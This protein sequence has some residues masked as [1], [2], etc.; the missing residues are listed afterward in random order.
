MPNEKSCFFCETSLSGGIDTW[1]PPGGPEFCMACWFEWERYEAR[2]RVFYEEYVKAEGLPR[3]W[4]GTSSPLGSR[5]EEV[6]G[7]LQ[8]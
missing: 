2:E 4:C 5:V 7:D 6:I 1:G 3:R 8:G